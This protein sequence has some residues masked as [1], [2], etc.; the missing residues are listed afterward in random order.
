MA[1]DGPRERTGAAIQQRVDALEQAAG[2]ST[3]GA[4]VLGVGLGIAT[5]AG[6]L[7]LF[8]IVWAVLVGVL[9]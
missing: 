3:A 1:G 2:A 4:L 8:I 9:H 6:G 5:V 7:G